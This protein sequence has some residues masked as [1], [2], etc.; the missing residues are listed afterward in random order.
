MD[1]A[2]NTKS[3][4]LGTVSDQD[5]FDEFSEQVEAKYGVTIDEP[6]SA[7]LADLIL[8]IQELKER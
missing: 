8:R 2:E 7:R 6:I 3:E 5:L 1:E 4:N